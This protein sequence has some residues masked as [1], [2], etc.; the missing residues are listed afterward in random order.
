MKHSQHHLRAVGCAL[1]GFTAW[2]IADTFMKLSGEAKLPPYEV[3]AFLGFFSVL[4]MIGKAGI[5]RKVTA[6]WP[7]NPRTQMIRAVLSLGSN[8]TSAIALKHLPMTSFYT[9]VFVAPIVIALLARVFLKEHL[10]WQKI[11]AI[12]AGFIGVVIAINP[13]QNM[14]SGDWVGYAAVAV[15]VLCFAASTVWLRVM[16]QSESVD[17]IAF[18]G[19]LVETVIC[20]SLLL[21]HF[22]VMSPWILG[23]LFGMAAFCLL[24]NLFNYTAMRMAHAATVVQ[25]HYTQIV[26]GA[27]VGYLIWHDIPALHMVLGAVIIIASGLYIATHKGRVPK[28]VKPSR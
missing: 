5:Q 17:S 22:E 21:W 27:I 24:G 14:S 11:I 3:I 26:T 16:T 28:R 25:F 23:A 7:H 9:A 18:F 2:V 20:G 4:L 8:L 1:A 12:L 13:F 6:L 10:T 19:G 15:N